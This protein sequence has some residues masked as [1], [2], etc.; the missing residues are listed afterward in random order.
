MSD[1]AVL[2]KY[3][4]VFLGDQSGTYP[5]KQCTHSNA[6]LSNAAQN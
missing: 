1:K 3:K 2:R 5:H 4:I 6:R